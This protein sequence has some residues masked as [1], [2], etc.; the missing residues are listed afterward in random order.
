MIQGRANVLIAFGPQG[1]V[2]RR[3]NSP[4]CH[5]FAV[6]QIEPD[7]SLAWLPEVMAA[8]R[9]ALAVDGEATVDFLI[10]RPLALG[11]VLELP[12]A[13]RG[14]LRPLAE[15]SIERFFPIDA[16]HWAA[17]AQALEGTRGRPRRTLVTALPKGLL[18]AVGESAERAGFRVGRIAA[19]PGAAA[20]H[21]QQQARQGHLPSTCRVELHLP[22]YVEAVLLERGNP[23][24]LIPLPQ[25]GEKQLRAMLDDASPACSALFREW[26]LALELADVAATASRIPQPR[27]ASQQVASRR[28]ARRRSGVLATATA[29]AVIAGF[30]LEI[31]GE[32]RE[33]SSL[34][35]VRQELVVDVQRHRELRRT[36]DELE[37]SLGQLA[38]AEGGGTAWPQI[39]RDLATA[40]P[41]SS[42]LTLV[43]G[44]PDSLLLTVSTD[45]ARALGEFRADAPFEVVSAEAVTGGVTRLSVSWT[46]DATGE[47]RA[48]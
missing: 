28:L 22:G 21:A 34:R 37:R 5:P 32:R 19:A 42:Y 16:E 30:G 25:P 6:S 23:I 2:A 40:L 27:T 47:I 43:S 29:L 7:S 35:W 26:T 18:E 15:A 1:L 33:L 11:K 41:D 8:A 45:D 4:G 12:P 10:L 14:A 48:D 36:L 46:G 17:D 24:G 9:E 20:I 13:R 44:R 39:F 3:L 31:I 38:S